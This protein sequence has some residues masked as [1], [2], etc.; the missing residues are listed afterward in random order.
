MRR[1]V[2]GV[3]ALAA[4]AIMAG[5]LL[6]YLLSDH[7]ACRRNAD[8]DR[9]ID[10]HSDAIWRHA[11]A[12]SLPTGLVRAVI[13][14][15]SGGDPRAV[16]PKGARGL[17]QITP[18]AE[19]HVIQETGLA[20]GDLFDPDYNILVGTTYLRMLVD[21]FSGD[22]RLALAAYHSGPTRVER[23]AADH[24]QLSPTDLIKRYAPRSTARY[25]RT[26][27]GAEAP[28]LARAGRGEPRR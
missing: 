10:A 4:A 14:A 21:R 12:N 9:R 23:L 8:K 27:L 22:L 19:R 18:V 28:R 25:V 7:V 17:M 20:K 15:E 26:I 16:S 5:A 24:P 6:G 2:T 13:K 3:T 1:L 11:S